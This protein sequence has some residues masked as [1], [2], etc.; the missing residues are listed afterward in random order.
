MQASNGWVIAMIVIVGVVIIGANYIMIPEVE[1]TDLT[2]LA[3]AIVAQIEIPEPQP[4]PTTRMSLREELKDEAIY[5]CDV[6]LEEDNYGYSK[7]KDVAIG[8]EFL[9]DRKFT[10]VKLGFDFIDDRSI[11]VDRTYRMSVNGHFKKLEVS[12]EVISDD[13]DLEADIEY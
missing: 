13:G 1:P 6:E 8:M 5:L 9:E 12:C 7:Y 11:K 3:A 2:P 10:E 4:L